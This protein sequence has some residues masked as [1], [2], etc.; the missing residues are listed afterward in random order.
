MNPETGLPFTDE[1]AWRFIATLL[2]DGH[3]VEE[4]ILD[5]PPGKTAWVLKVELETHKPR[6][7]VKLHLGA[8]GKVFGRSF[9]YSDR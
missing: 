8:N 4:M 1:S 6:L 3:E 7:Y 9:H 5:V 2:R